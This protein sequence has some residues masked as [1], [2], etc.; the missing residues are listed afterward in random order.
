MALAVLIFH[1]DKWLTG[2]WDA[3]SVQGKLGVYA[4]STFFVLSGLTLSLVYET[5]LDASLKSWGLFFRKRFWRI[6]PL[7]W[8]ATAATLLIDNSQR[9]IQDIVLNFS[10]L[11][12]FVNPAKDIAT[13]AWSIGCELVFYAGFPTLL[14]LA[15]W[16]RMAFLGCF[17]LFLGLGVWTAFYSFGPDK[18]LQSDWWPV[19]AQSINHAYFFVGGM[20]L[21]VFRKELGALPRS[22][23]QILLALAALMFVYWPVGQAPFALVNGW[24]RVVFSGLT[25]LAVAAWFQGRIVLKGLP[26]QFLTW[27]GAVSYSLYLLHPLVF[28]GIKS[29]FSK[30]GFGDGYWGLYLVALAA[31]LV[32]SHLSYF[33]LEKPLAKK[34]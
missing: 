33:L 20:A 3:A 27:L 26:H 23:W 32:L 24:N 6:Y 7:L 11:F 16:N 18:T 31:T 14:L 30:I 34:G 22:Y 8:L 4:V 2:A 9:E 21:G 13:G 29:V 10:G 15:R 28:R 12:G 19:Y 1:F 17:L 25:I 5:R